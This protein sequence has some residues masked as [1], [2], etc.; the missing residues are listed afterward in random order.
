MTK[1]SIFPAIYA[2]TPQGLKLAL[3]LR[4]ALGGVC[5]A[6]QALAG[7]EDG[8]RGFAS[9]PR[10]VEESFHEF[11]QHIFIAATGI[12][13]RCLAP[14]MADKTVDPAVVALDQ[15]GKFA[16]S[17]LSGHLGGANELAARVAKI[18]GG[19]AVITTA[20][21][22]EG[23]P[24]VDLLALRAG[25]R[26][27]NPENIKLINAALLAGKRIAL[28]DPEDWLRESLPFEELAY[29]EIIADDAAL[30]EFMA[31]RPGAPLVRVSWREFAPPKNCLLL[32][33]PALRLGVGC[34]K[35]AEAGDILDHAREVCAEGGLDI[36]AVGCLASAEVK[37][38]EPGLL[39]VAREL[40]VPLHI[41]N[42]EELALYPPS[43]V[44][45]KAMEVVG[46]PG[47]CEPAA[48]A[49]AGGG[50]LLVGKRVKGPV[51]LAVA[52][53]ASGHKS[54]KGD[55]SP[56]PSAGQPGKLY[57]CGLG[58]GDASLLTPQAEAVLRRSEEI[59]GYATYVDL[60]PPELLAGKK[61]TRG[62][63]GGE[64]TR[65]AAALRAAKAGRVV[66]LVSS[67]DAGIY[68][69]AGLVLELAEEWTRT[70]AA[71]VP[72]EVEIIPGVPALCAAAARLG[73]PL[74]HDFAVISLSDLLTPWELI[75]KRLKAAVA[76]DFVLVLYNP[77]S[78][79]RGEKF[80]RALEILR[81]LCGGERP[82]GL[83][84]EAFRPGEKVSAGRLD[85]LEPGEVDMLSLVIVGNSQTRR[86]KNR[87]LTPRGYLAKYA[88]ELGS[89]GPLPEGGGKK[90]ETKV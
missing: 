21:D 7:G 55:S 75:E 84:R 27:G 64:V 81:D 69:M 80:A 35:G 4:E 66:A 74:M 34:R 22:A 40:G 31:Q 37:A 20:T 76:A 14:L 28:H 32:V 90:R 44:S 61:V 59:F 77:N 43:E 5:F 2:L 54:G 10:L 56:T 19:A 47:V 65:C 71:H 38:E 36:R 42:A 30:A 41:F 26:I 12:V 46:L 68:G 29:F 25:L 63:M 70:D 72:P 16:V 49:A 1:A 67:G 18:T 89:A 9:L 24:A 48:R 86:C 3:R 83:V 11:R 8:A 62:R 88:A 85:E 23:L 60:L 87:L 6:P 53:A 58:P 51:T 39:A 13:L 82:Y 78:R 15:K 79:G 57:V 52:L 45:A 50:P 33:P 17:L 73:A